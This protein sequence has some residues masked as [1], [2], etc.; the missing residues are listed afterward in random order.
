LGV[1]SQRLTHNAEN[2]VFLG[3]LG[4]GKSHPAIAMGIEA[5]NAGFKVYFVNA[6]TP[7]F[8]D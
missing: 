8:K 6:G 2:L 3:P 1:P 5:V 4:V 7:L